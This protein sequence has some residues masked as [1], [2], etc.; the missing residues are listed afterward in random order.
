[1]A[2]ISELQ[3]DDP[4]QKDYEAE[5]HAL[6]FT[7]HTCRHLYK[8]HWRMGQSVHTAQPACRAVSEHATES[9]VALIL[10]S[11]IIASNA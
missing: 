11:I 4:Q 8:V 10:A 9:D 2:S 3:N 5:R 7:D 6:F 1:M